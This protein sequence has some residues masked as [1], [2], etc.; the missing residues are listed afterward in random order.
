MSLSKLTSSFLNLF[1]TKNTNTPKSHALVI[2]RDFNHFDMERF[3]EFREKFNIRNYIF[4]S[5][6]EIKFFIPIVSFRKLT[7]DYI[8]SFAISYFKCFDFYKK[9]DLNFVEGFLLFHLEAMR[10][11]RDHS[12]HFF[13]RILSENYINV[14]HTYTTSFVIYPLGEWIVN[15]LADLIMVGPMTR[16]YIFF[17]QKRR[18]MHD[19]FYYSNYPAIAYSVFQGSILGCVINRTSE[20]VI[21]TYYNVS[22]IYEYICNYFPKQKEMLLDLLYVTSNAYTR[23]HGSFFLY[24]FVFINFVAKSLYIRSS[25]V[26]EF[27]EQFNRGLF[28]R[29]HVH[30]NWDY[31]YILGCIFYV[32]SGGESN[33]GPP[34]YSKILD[35]VFP[36]LNDI[37]QSYRDMRNLA[38]NGK[39]IFIIALYLN[40]LTDQLFSFISTISRSMFASTFD[41]F[42]KVSSL[43]ITL[44]ETHKMIMGQIGVTFVSANAQAGDVENFFLSVGLAAMLPKSLKGIFKDMQIFTNLKFLDDI[45]LFHEFLSFIVSL[46]RRIFSLF[47]YTGLG[48]D[49]CAEISNVL[50]DFEMMLPFSELGVLTRN[51]EIINGEF[52][53]DHRLHCNKVF[54][55]RALSFKTSYT[56]IKQ[57][58]LTRKRA[59]P[60]YFVNTSLQYERLLKLINY[61]VTDTRPEPVAIVFCG[62]PG[63]GKSCLMANLINSYKTSQTIYTDTPTDAMKKK[64]YD[65]YQNEDIYVVDDMGAKAVSQWSEIVNQVSTVKYKLECASIE[66]KD[67]KFFTSPLMLISTNSIPTAQVVTPTDGLKDLDA[68][69]RRLHKFD[70]SDV[71]FKN[72]VYTGK[73][74]LKRYDLTPGVQSWVTKSV[75][76][77]TSHDDLVKHVDLY[78]REQM[79][80]RINIFKNL[81]SQ[82]VNLAP[83]PLCDAQSKLSDDIFMG[84]RSFCSKIPLGATAFDT[85]V[86][87][88][89]DANQMLEKTF[90]DLAKF[91]DKNDVSSVTIISITALLGVAVLGLG[92]TLHSYFSEPESQIL[93]P[94]HYT[95]NKISKQ[96]IIKIIPQ[97]VSDI[98][99]V[100][101]DYIEA[102]PQLGKYASNMIVLNVLR[103]VDGVTI[104]NFVSAL[105]SVDK[106]LVPLHSVYKSDKSRVFFTAYTRGN[107]ILYDK[108]EANIVYTNEA[109]DVAI[110]QIPKSAPKFFRKLKIVVKS[111][112]TDLYFLTPGGIID[113]KEKISQASVSCGYVSHGYHGQFSAEDLSYTYNA[114]GFCGAW[115]V[116]SDGFL[117]AMH[118]AAMVISQN[119]KESTLGVARVIRISCLN[120]IQKIF[121]TTFGVVLPVVELN[122]DKFSGAKLAV[123][124]PN[125]VNNKSS[126]VP[127]LVHGIYP[128]ERRPAD[129]KDKRKIL[130]LS[131]DAFTE[132]PNVRLDAVEFAKEVVTEKLAGPY[133]TK[134]IGL[135]ERELVLGND[136][137]NRIDP[138]TSP[139]CGYPGGKKE[140]LDYENGTIRPVMKAKVREFV[141]NIISDNFKYDEYY[142]TTFKDELRNVDLTGKTKDPRIFQAGTLLLTLLYRFFF[143]ELMVKTSRNRYR[144]G[145]MVGMNPLSK[146]WDLFTRK[147]LS[148]SSR[149]MYDGDFKWWDKRMHPVFQRYLSSVFKILINV[150]HMLPLFNEIFDLNLTSEQLSMVFDVLLEIIISTPTRLLDFIFITTHNMPSGVGVTAF[151]NSCIHLM[152][153]AFVYFS[154]CKELDKVPTVKEFV[155]E[156]DDYVYGDDK[157]LNCSDK[158]KN[159]MDP[160]HFARIVRSIGLDFTKADKTSWKEGETMNLDD[161][162]FLKR[163]FFLHP[164]IKQWVGPLETRSMCST[165]N[166]ISDF[167]R[168]VELTTVKLENFQRELYLHYFSYDL[169]MQHVINFISNKDLNPKFLSEK[170]LIELYSQGLYDMNINFS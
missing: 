132:T 154:R 78:I 103:E 85:M 29:D 150:S 117:V 3:R 77:I 170:T 169:Q 64:F 11:E 65:S 101:T 93:P 84:M 15:A 6:F 19:L 37:K 110:L 141:N 108:M 116:N 83:L 157:L 52:L 162:T 68:F 92:A 129:F 100:T 36:K 122:N 165:L 105:I 146:E 88:L 97:S 40:R 72:G 140:W 70:F 124:V 151:Y 14:D 44:Y 94:K 35:Y 12:Y 104:S 167:K 113:M 73:L 87:L 13:S 51:L 42:T 128:E 115:I 1:T 91:A 17:T 8:V 43:I 114:D 131:M 59:L 152:V 142:T 89:G 21:K 20:S 144:N 62:P 26:Q 2:F 69:Y 58:F 149:N 28:K 106:I 120:E 46:P 127:S 23:R 63:T 82:I 18:D 86:D 54:Q 119:G 168:D 96:D 10:C 31:D 133:Q 34:I 155:Q 134:F 5:I 135:T 53:K 7:S 48:K 25:V 41:M 143:G 47:E 148:R 137:L 16:V 126:I 57:Y 118:C 164:T 160:F 27:Y 166:Y 38:S 125:F 56:K 79:Q 75:F 107:S 61:A 60:S 24:D 90:P 30:I 156:I 71:V 50:Y 9:M 49:L 153:T 33:P 163:S 67:S 81:N 32:L 145:I 66:N 39:D 22:N 130:S 111:Q 102:P 136:E 161:V 109:N 121:D 147:I 112:N 123:E 139:G 98:L 138:N 76:P 80:D 158:V 159:L 55:A 74:A 45:T 4:Y 99:D 95:A